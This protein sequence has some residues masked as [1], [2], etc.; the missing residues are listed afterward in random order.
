[1]SFIVDIIIVAI[2]LLFTFIGYKRGLVKLAFS[3]CSFFIAIAIAFSIYKPVTNIL[4]DK[5]SIDESISKAITDK[6][7]PEGASVNSEIKENAN[8]PEIIMN[9]GANTIGELSNSFSTTIVGVCCFIVIYIIVK[10]AL[11]FVTALANL[12]AKLPLLK[13]FNKLGG[14]IY[15]VTQGIFIVF[16]GFA[17]I[18][19]ASP[20]MDAEILS[21]I[22]NS[23]LG[24]WIYNNNLLL[25]LI[26]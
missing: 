11:R 3:L 25:N 6:I 4:L 22:N 13:Q 7:L 8:L 10:I 20:L 16:L 18:S 12:I 24:S 2:I 17:V 26:K 5:T 9:K 15:G 19:L 23:M 1:M 21:N 14:L